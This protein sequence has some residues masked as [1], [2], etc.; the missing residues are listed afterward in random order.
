M[1]N[2]FYVGQRVRANKSTLEIYVTG[3]GDSPNYP[4]FAGVAIKGGAGYAIGRYS[5]AWTKSSFTPIDPPSTVLTDWQR[6]QIRE[7]FFLMKHI[8]TSDDDFNAIESILSEPE[9]PKYK[10]KHGEA[11]QLRDNDSDMWLV[12]VFYEMTDDGIY[13]GYNML[14]KFCRPFDAALVG[15]VT[16]D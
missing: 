1:A 2:K 14:G 9:P 4:S 5:A 11:V 6:K 13:K 12:D 15:K 3:E 7:Y 16:N 10:P 8:S